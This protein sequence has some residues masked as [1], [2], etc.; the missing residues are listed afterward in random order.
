LGHNNENALAEPQN[1]I[2][3]EVEKAS[4]L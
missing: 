4:I 1:L 3:K 2:W